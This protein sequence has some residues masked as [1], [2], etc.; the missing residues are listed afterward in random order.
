MGDSKVRKLQMTV[1]EL[2]FFAFEIA[3]SCSINGPAEAQS[4]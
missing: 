1:I 3:L 4:L 2:V